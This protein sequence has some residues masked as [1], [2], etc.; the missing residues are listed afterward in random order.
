MYL[1]TLIISHLWNKPPVFLC[2]Q[3]CL[4]LKSHMKACLISYVFL[5]SQNL[6]YSISVMSPLPSQVL[7]QINIV[8][9]P[10]AHQ[11]KWVI[12]IHKYIFFWS[13]HIV[14][15]ESHF[16]TEMGKI[17]VSVLDLSELK[18]NSDFS[19]V[20]KWF[21]RRNIWNAVL[22]VSIKFYHIVVS[23]ANFLAQYLNVSWNNPKHWERSAGLVLCVPSC[24]ASALELVSV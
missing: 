22:S 11:F 19:E 3:L 2:Y 21:T 9:F 5:K 13:A 12:C 6:I 4:F 10:G 15:Q 1:F 20:V 24:V 23:P 17:T 18:I 7:S 8:Q 14:L 16:A